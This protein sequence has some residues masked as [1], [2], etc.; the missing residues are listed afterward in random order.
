MMGDYQYQP[1]LD[2]DEKDC[3]PATCAIAIIPVPYDMTSTWKKGADKGPA[4]ILDASTQV[5]CY[6]IETQSEVYRKGITTLPPV[7][8]KGP[9]EELA[10]LVESQVNEVFQKKQ[11][12]VILGGEHSVSIGAINAAVGNFLDLSVLQIDA[13]SDTREEYEGSNHNHACVMA[14]AR[15]RCEIVQ[16]GIRAIDVSETK[17]MDKQ[18]VFF[19]HEIVN[20]PDKSWMDRVID[21][22]SDNVYVTIDLDAFDPSLLPAT[23]TPEPGGLSW[24]EINELLSRVIAS[25]NVIG[26]DVVELLP[27][28][29]HHASAFTAAKLVHRVLS[30]IFSGR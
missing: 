25:K 6:D 17:T 9:P 29:G 28:E 8:C 1:F 19:A 30:M 5:E 11:L 2:L 27:M 3:D 12:P 24:Y 23:G 13:H 18:R 20:N 10:E 7:I 22:L 4:A 26:F 15:E 14:R 21:L 16:V